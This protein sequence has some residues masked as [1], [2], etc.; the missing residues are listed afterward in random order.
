MLYYIGDFILI[1]WNARFN[2]FL[3]LKNIKFQVN[4]ITR[5][6]RLR[7]SAYDQA[8][9]KILSKNYMNYN[10]I[11]NDDYY[12]SADEPC[13]KGQKFKGFEPCCHYRHDTFDLFLPAGWSKWSQWTD[14]TVSCDGGTRVRQRVCDQKEDFE[15]SCL[16]DAKEIGECG[17]LPCNPIGW[18][19]WT[20][21]TDC[22]KTC[23]GGV[24][25]RDRVCADICPDRRKYH[26][27]R[28]K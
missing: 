20:G 5:S 17:T 2:R 23:G 26:K 13:C 22:S 19:P 12:L 18:A 7:V 4:L 1:R 8:D 25:F 15:N 16:G 9:A 10:K 21:W 24:Q 6:I 27:V 28:L 11:N 14:C 3:I